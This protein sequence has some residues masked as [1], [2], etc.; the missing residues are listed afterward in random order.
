MNSLQLAGVAA[1]ANSEPKQS[2]RLSL[3]QGNLE[4]CKSNPNIAAGAILKINKSFMNF[5]V[6]INSAPNI[7]K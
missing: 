5:L 1:V 4:A 2:L 6:L 7:K 3:S